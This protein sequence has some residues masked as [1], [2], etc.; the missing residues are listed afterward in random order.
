MINTQFYKDIYYNY[1]RPN[2]VYES[3]YDIDFEL[4]YDD[5]IRHLFFDIDNTI[6]SYKE[7]GVSLQCLNLF[8]SIL[9]LE[10]DTVALISNNS[11][12][13]RVNKV[14]KQLKLPAVAF[15]CKPFP[16]AMRR[17]LEDANL[18][19][20][21]CAFIGDQLMTDIILANT[22]GLKSI[23]VEPL[24]TSSVSKLRLLQYKVQE[25]L[26]NKF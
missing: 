14:A 7:D 2:L 17:V 19:P 12:Y 20:K 8:N 26:L 9:N 22:L 15:A 13:D 11:S 24:D 5:G 23:F 1:V 25:S 18:N 16:F 4:L 3:V 10:F 6:I 21:E